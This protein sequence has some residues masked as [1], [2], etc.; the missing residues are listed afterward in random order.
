LSKVS[1]I[2]IIYL[3]F[4][5]FFAF[6]FIWIIGIIAAPVFL[7]SDNKILIEISAIIYAFFGK[8]CHQI[9]DRSYFLFGKQF[10]VC[11]RCSFIY[12]GFFISLLIILIRRKINNY[13]SPK[14]F[15]LFLS[16]LLIIVDVLFEYF[17]I[18][19]GNYITRSLTGFN[20][21]FLLPLYLLPGL[22]NIIGKE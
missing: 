12:L 2:K 21:G 7:F 19:S 15:Y 9:S 18:Y 20:I 16:V 6:T 3:N 17:K 13:E 11:S 10:A 14:Q 5:I 22:N 4:Y 1:K 8:T